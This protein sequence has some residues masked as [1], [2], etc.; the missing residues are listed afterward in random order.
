VLAEVLNLRSERRLDGANH[1]TMLFGKSAQEI[2]NI[3]DDLI[4]QTH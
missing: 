4:Q 2:A 1:Y 3:I